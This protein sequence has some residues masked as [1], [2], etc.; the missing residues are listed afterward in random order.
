[1]SYSVGDGLVVLGLGAGVVGYSYVKHQSRTRRLAI[2]HQERLVTM[3][4]DGVGEGFSGCA[5]LKRQT[6]F[7]RLGTWCSTR[8]QDL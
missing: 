7:V 6:I 2:I 1:M 8:M 3:E 4:K 5:R